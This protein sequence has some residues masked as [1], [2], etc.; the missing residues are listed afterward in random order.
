[1]SLK[2]KTM[3]LENKLI[4]QKCPSAISR[5]YRPVCR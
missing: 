3:V 2:G 1:M 5:K 4:A